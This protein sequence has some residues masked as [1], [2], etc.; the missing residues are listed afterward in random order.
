MKKIISLLFI[1]LLFSA[2]STGTS[3][4]EAAEKEKDEEAIELPTTVTLAGED[5]AFD[6]S[7]TVESLGHLTLNESSF[8]QGTIS[9]KMNTVTFTLKYTD[10]KS[11]V[12]ISVT[13]DWFGNQADINEEYQQAIQ[14][15]TIKNIRFDYRYVNSGFAEYNGVDVMEID[16]STLNDWFKSDTSV[17]DSGKTIINLTSDTANIDVDYDKTTKEVKSLSFN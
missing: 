16:E 4:N 6:G 5:I 17:F 15:G 11:T 10:G 8:N 2:C 14:S 12:S 9:T 3:N 13:T 7:D 1:A